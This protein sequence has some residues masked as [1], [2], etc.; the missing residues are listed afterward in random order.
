MIVSNT[1]GVRRRPGTLYVANV[2]PTANHNVNVIPFIYSQDEA[3]VLVLKTKTVTGSPYLSWQAYKQ[4]SYLPEAIGTTTDILLEDDYDVN[5][6]Q[7]VQS[8]DTLWI[9][10]GVNPPLRIIR[11][12]TNTFT[13][14]FATT[15]VDD[16]DTNG[17]LTR[18]YR[19]INT[20]ATT[21]TPAATTGSNITLTAST[22]NF[23]N[24]NMV[25]TAGTFFNSTYFKITRV[26]VTGVC[27]C[28]EYVSGT[29]MK[30]DILVNFGDTSAST[31]WQE[32]SWSNHRGWPKTVALYESRLLYGGNTSQPDTVWGSEVYRYKNFM[33]NVLV[34]D[35]ASNVSGLNFYGDQTE[36]FPFSFTISAP[37]VNEIT[38]MQSGKTLTVGTSGQEFSATGVGD[39][40]LSPTSVA[41][42]DQT[43]IGS[44]RVQAVRINKS[45]VF[46]TRNGKQFYS[47]SYDNLSANYT[48]E[49]L[50]SLADNIVF[51]NALDESKTLGAEDTQSA[52]IE[53]D[54]SKVSYIDWTQHR[55]CLWVLANGDLIGCT[56]DP[57]VK[58][59]AWHR[60]ILGGEWVDTNNITRYP[61]VVGMCVLPTNGGTADRLWMIVKRTINGSTVYQLEVMMDDYNRHTLNESD[62]DLPIFTDSSVV[63]NATG[64]ATT[65]TGLSHLIGETVDVLADGFP[66]SQKVV[67]ASGSIELDLEASGLVIVGLPYTPVLQLMPTEAGSAMGSAIGMMT[68]SHRA[69]LR[70]DKSA[71]VR[72]TGPENEEETDVLPGVSPMDTNYNLFT[73]DLDFD[74]PGSTERR[75]Q[76]IITQ[77]QPLPMN[78]L[79]VTLR[80]V[81]YD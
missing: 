77:N 23:F 80:G 6:V 66:C 7:Y 12:A 5:N 16:A 60:H 46:V 81:T 68:R 70:M 52:L 30:V 4:T 53:I 78:I 72:V 38:W 37:R 31:S 44:S 65:V 8:A 33:Q 20:T 2:S 55:K 39:R 17:V 42:T 11:T 54:T 73:G 43:T 76:L 14:N 34:Q 49:S 28:V 50:N 59:L 24:A 64:G 71:G 51:Q 48:G 10:D 56:I 45:T 32:S 1:G 62:V 25:A 57:S 13:V 19:D 61:R 41:F 58:T 35:A 22:A 74:I 26:G 18:P 36:L 9:C 75:Q 69:T 47:H 27:R 21:L 15:F 79:N 40:I 67:D 29:E 3:Y 63:F